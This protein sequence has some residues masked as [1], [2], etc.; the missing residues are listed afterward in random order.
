MGSGAAGSQA[1]RGVLA[2]LARGALGNDYAPDVPGRMLSSIE[3]LASGSERSQLDAT[4]RALDSRM[5]ALA[6]TG[7]AVP[8]SWLSTAEAER[9]LQKWIGSRLPLQR[10]LGGAL[11]SLAAQALYGYPGP[12]WARLGYPGP[13][14]HAPAESRSLEPLAVTSDE[15]L[16]CDVVVVGSGAGGGCVA[17]GLAE[18]GLDVVV[19]E[20]GSYR[21]E[22]DYHHLEGDAMRELYLYGSTLTTRDMDVLV[23][24]GS[25][26]GGGT[27]VNYSTSFKTPPHVLKQWSEV[28]GVEAFSSGEFEEHLDAAAERV[29]VNTDSSAAG[30]RDEVIEAG[31]KKLGTTGSVRTTN[32]ASPM[33]W[34]KARAP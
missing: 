21:A 1:A 29:G 34:S 11:T 14:G 3:Q 30:K 18:A 28:S 10:R 25:T 15:T 8:V 7:R 5:G 27:V 13:I 24:A 20:K 9:L 17:A 2:A 31:L 4:L 23:L 6:L 16:T 22:S 19:V 33:A 12:A 26:L 32:A